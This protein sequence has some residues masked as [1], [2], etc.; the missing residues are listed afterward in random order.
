MDVELATAATSMLA[1]KTQNA[2]Q[3]ALLKKQH[4][5]EMSVVNLLAEA[6]Q[7]PPPAGMGTIIDKRV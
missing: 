2:M 1:A 3:I 7:A 6:V 5:M 4:E